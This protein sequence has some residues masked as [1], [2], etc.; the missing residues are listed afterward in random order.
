MLEVPLTAL[1]QPTIVASSC[2]AIQ[3]KSQET[4]TNKRALDDLT[5][6]PFQPKPI[7]SHTSEIIP[8]LSDQ[9]PR[10]A[11]NVETETIKLVPTPMR[12]TQ[13]PQAPWYITMALDK[14]PAFS[15]VT[16]ENVDVPESKASNV[17][18]K[19]ITFAIPRAITQPKPK[20]TIDLAP[21]ALIAVAESVAS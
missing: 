19:N 21:T 3:P 8:L 4:S 7:Q 16:R 2:F 20:Q 11:P 9:A 5:I 12:C 13:L 15:P 18:K 14:T 6:P 17:Q 1:S 10:K